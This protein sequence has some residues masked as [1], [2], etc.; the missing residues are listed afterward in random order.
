MSIDLSKQHYYEALHARIKGTWRF[1]VYH[2]DPA[3]QTEIIVHE[4]THDAAYES[5]EAAE[6]AACEWA[7]ANGIDAEMA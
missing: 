1:K 7:E 3:G 4:S 5:I 6:D 2:Y